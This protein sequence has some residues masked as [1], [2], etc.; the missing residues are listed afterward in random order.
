MPEITTPQAHTQQT[1]QIQEIAGQITGPICF[2][3]TAPADVNAPYHIPQGIVEQ[4]FVN[5]STLRIER[6]FSPG[7]LLSITQGLMAILIDLEEEKCIHGDICPEHLVLELDDEGMFYT[8]KG[9]QRS[10]YS[11]PFGEVSVGGSLIYKPPFIFT[12]KHHQFDNKIDTWSAGVTLLLLCI[13]EKAQAEVGNII[14]SYSE[15][16]VDQ[17]S[18]IML[19][20]RL[21]AWIEKC[22]REVIQ[23]NFYASHMCHLLYRLLDPDPHKSYSAA[24]AFELSKHLT[25]NDFFTLL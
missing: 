19:L 1:T 23:K 5:A 9:L 24:E 11:K 21:H 6:S 16:D 15:T 4:Q 8:F 7:E 18:D 14:Y 22:R 13:S 25:E 20:R 12:E 17:Q 2:D 3:W 10:A